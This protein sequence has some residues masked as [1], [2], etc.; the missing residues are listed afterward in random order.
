M[1]V[2]VTGA[3]GLV[4][5]AICNY[6]INSKHQVTGI[7]NNHSLKTDN[8]NYNELKLNLLDDKLVLQN[9][10]YDAVIHCAAIIAD[11]SKTEQ[12]IVEVNQKIDTHVFNF[13]KTV[14]KSLL[15]FMYLSVTITA[16]LSSTASPFTV[17][18]ING[19]V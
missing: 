7:I 3:S 10:N 4:G 14:N 12:E 6:F 5:E 8:P 16:H 11:D 2:L 15:R 9:N 13:C 18:T 1:H 19:D 17:L